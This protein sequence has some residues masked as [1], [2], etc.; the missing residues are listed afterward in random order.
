MDLELLGLIL[1][2][3]IG[4]PVLFVAKMHTLKRRREGFEQLAAQLGFEILGDSVD[5]EESTKDLLLFHR[6]VRR[7]TSNVIR[8]EAAGESVTVTDYYYSSGHGS[9]S[10]T[11]SQTVVLIESDEMRFPGFQLSARKKYYA[12]NAKTIGM[13]EVPVNGDRTFRA[14]YLLNAESPAVGEVFDEQLVRKINEGPLIYIECFQGMFVF[15]QYRLTKPDEL[16]QIIEAAF[17]MRSAVLESA[18][19]ALPQVTSSFSSND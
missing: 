6:G 10:T 7:S 16:K 12:A 3:V 8:G 11:S 14:N 13:T 2:G 15:Q 17:E 5:L 19:N 1:L 4:G 18:E 9:N